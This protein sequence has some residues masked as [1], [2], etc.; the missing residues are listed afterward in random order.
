[1]ERRK[2]R[3]ILGRPAPVGQAFQNAGQPVGTMR[4]VI[5]LA[6]QGAVDLT[7]ARGV[8]NGNIHSDVG[9]GETLGHVFEKALDKD[10]GIVIVRQVQT[11]DKVSRRS[12]CQPV[13]VPGNQPR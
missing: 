8:E 9:V 5:P 6:S 13:S 10:A 11:V 1:M 7:D 3:A 2:R 12:R 4:K